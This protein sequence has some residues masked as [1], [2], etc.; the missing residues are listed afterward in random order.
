MVRQARR[1]TARL[2]VAGRGRAR[3]G[4]FMD[5]L[6]LLFEFI[7]LT[8]VGRRR[9]EGFIVNMA[10]CV[11]WFYV[12]LTFNL[13][14]LAGVAVLMFFTNINNYYKWRQDA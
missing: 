12:G 4:F 13:Y 14:G 9:K 1:G 2:G 7:G 3:Q 5:W 6:A 10:G 11:C 8:I